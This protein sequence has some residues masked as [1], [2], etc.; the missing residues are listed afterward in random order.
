MTDHDLFVTDRPTREPRPIDPLSCVALLLL[1]ARS[2]DRFDCRRKREGE[3]NG[4]KPPI[5]NRLAAAAAKVCYIGGD[6]SRC[7]HLESTSPSLFRI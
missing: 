3:G 1:L 2:V 4:K 7:R 6:L 5:Y